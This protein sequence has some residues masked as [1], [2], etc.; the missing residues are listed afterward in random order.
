MFKKR[1]F[2][3][4]KWVAHN[5]FMMKDKQDREV[6]RVCC[7]CIKCGIAVHKRVYSNDELQ[8]LEQEFFERDY[9]DLKRRESDY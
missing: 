7:V 4:H 6:P 1:K 5:C 9:R 8:K 3:K 2:C